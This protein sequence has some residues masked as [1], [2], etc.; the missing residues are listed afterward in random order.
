MGE[1]LQSQ[2]QLDSDPW[3][4]I[5]ALRMPAI[6]A[7][8]EFARAV[9]ACTNHVLAHDNCTVWPVCWIVTFPVLQSRGAAIAPPKDQKL[10]VHDLGYYEKDANEGWVWMP[11][12]TAKDSLHICIERMYGVRTPGELSAF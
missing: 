11:M 8:R 4:A 1:I 12:V 2:T 3:L 6:R 10:A 7:T 5:S 9:I